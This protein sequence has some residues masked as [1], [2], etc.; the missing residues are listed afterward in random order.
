VNA[1]SQRQKISEM[2]EESESSSDL[3]K[4]APEE[5]EKTVSKNR[6]R[7]KRIVDSEIALHLTP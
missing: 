4:E 6:I 5:K 7:I 1:A 2:K 3:A